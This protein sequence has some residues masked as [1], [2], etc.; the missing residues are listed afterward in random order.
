MLVLRL[1]KKKKTDYYGFNFS[2]QITSEI[3]YIVIYLLNNYI[4]SSMKVL[5]AQSYTTLWNAMDY[6]PPGS[7]LHG[8]FQ[9]RI[10]EW[11]AI[12]FSR[13]SSQTRDQTQVSCGRGRFF[14]CCTT[15]EAQYNVLIYIMLIQFWVVSYYWFCS[16]L[17]IH[18]V[19]YW[20]SGF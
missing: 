15:K 18:N 12:P 7:S 10:L 13:G 20:L 14:T 19:I 17:Y 1:S 3:E 5:V 2:H 9:A 16:L 4:F 11:V 8:I 6:S